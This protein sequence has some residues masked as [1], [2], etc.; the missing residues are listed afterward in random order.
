MALSVSTILG[1]SAAPAEYKLHLACWNGADH[2]LDVFVADRSEWDGW[3]SWRGSRDDFNRRYILSFIEFYPEPS[4]WLFG[5]VYEVTGRGGARYE[6]ALDPKSAALIGRLKVQLKRP[7]RAKAFRLEGCLDDMVVSEVLREPYSGEAFPGYDGISHP[8]AQIETII[9]RSRPDWKA[10]LEHVK[11]VYLITDLHAAKRYVGAAYGASG[12]WSRWASYVATGHG[13][14]DELC[15]V[16]AA[17]GLDYARQHF[18]LTLLEY[19]PMKAEDR[20]IIAREV[21]WK[22][23]LLTRVPHGYNKN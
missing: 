10:A 20:A 3:N 17:N 13:W 18:R 9:R 5:G 6:L 15:A 7:G 8:F 23:A 21:F 19:H 11:G 12:L 22:D 16:I 14:N 4:T 2:P 1:L